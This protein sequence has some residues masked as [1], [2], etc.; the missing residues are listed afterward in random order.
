MGKRKIF[1]VLC[2]ISVRLDLTQALIFHV[3]IV[4]GLLMFMAPHLI[5]SFS[6][7]PKASQT[8]MLVMECLLSVCLVRSRYFIAYGL[9]SS[10]SSVR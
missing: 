2:S 3:C 9:P 1:G 4:D 8:P 10:S 5:Q 7:C 6:R